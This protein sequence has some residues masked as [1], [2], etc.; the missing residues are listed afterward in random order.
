M[1]KSG[2]TSSIMIDI[3]S[4]REGIQKNLTEWGKDNFRQFQWRQSRTPYSVLI[5][6]LL[7][8]R[9]TAKAVKGVFKEF[10]CLYPN[11]GA[12]SQAE[13][14]ELERFLSKIGYHKQRTKILVDLANYILIKYSGEIPRSK[15][16]LLEIPN[17]GDYTANA[18]LS[19]GYG[20]PSAMVDSNVERILGRVFLKH[21]SKRT[22]SMIQRVAES[23]APTKDNQDYNYALLD[24][25]ALVCK[26]GRPRCNL[27]PISKFCDYYMLGK[28]HSNPSCQSGQ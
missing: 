10:M 22:H 13:A 25:G 23:L 11:L 24:L 3:E 15:E 26:Y 16:D 12:L 7:L 27:C 8:R 28:Q 17:I 4:K 18:I 21:L 6:E 9:T 5:S 14:R 19:L 2:L 20:I 1:R